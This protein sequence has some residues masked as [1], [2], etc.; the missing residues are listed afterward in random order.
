MSETSVSVLDV[1]LAVVLSKLTP[2]PDVA[3]RFA[4]E[5][6]VVVIF[7]AFEPSFKVFACVLVET[8]SDASVSTGVQLNVNPSVFLVV[9]GFI[10]PV[11]CIAV[12]A[13]VFNGVAVPGKTDIV[14]FD[15]L[16]VSCAEVSNAVV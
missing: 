9:V 8:P 15:D 16:A 12:V 14:S 4:D 2:T 5:I 7:G 3:D 1:L 6:A 13:G 11:S 10:L